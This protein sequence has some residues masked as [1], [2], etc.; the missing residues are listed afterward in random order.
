MA[1]EDLMRER[2]GELGLDDFELEPDGAVRSRS[3]TI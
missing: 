2:A 1:L 3:T